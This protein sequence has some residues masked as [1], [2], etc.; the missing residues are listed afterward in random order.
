MD[1]FQAASHE[2]NRVQTYVGLVIGAAIVYAIVRVRDIESNR[3]SIDNQPIITYFTSPI[4]SLNLPGPKWAKYTKI[5]FMLKDLAGEKGNVL[6]EYHLKYGPIVQV[7]PDEISFLSNGAIRDL[8]MGSNPP[9]IGDTYKAFGSPG[10]MFTS[11]DPLHREKKKRITH[12]F[13]Q[14]S[15]NGLEPAL[16]EM[17]D[18]VFSVFRKNIG[19]PLDVIHWVKMMN[20]DLA[21]E[22]FFGKPFGAME[23][24]EKAVEYSH[25]IDYAFLNYAM[26][27]NMGLLL[28]LFKLLLPLLPKDLQ[29]LTKSARYLDD[30]SHRQRRSR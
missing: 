18:K 1:R 13:S 3:I 25:M 2:F 28:K 7:A 14:T 10:Q 27:E 9:E 22:M 15:L 20:L 11:R 8:Y 12:L 30:V 17:S 26:R 4:R 5:P 23:E 19:K 29:D 6:Q 21:G 24:E 16:R